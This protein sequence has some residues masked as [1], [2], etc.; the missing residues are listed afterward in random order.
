V[1]EALNGDEAEQWR[2]ALNEEFN[3]LNSNNTWKL[4][5]L[6]KDRKAIDVK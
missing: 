4:V 3:L 1:E 2:Q 5:D 6:P